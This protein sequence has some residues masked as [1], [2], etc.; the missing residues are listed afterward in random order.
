MTKRNKV[1]IT[2][3]LISL[4]AA[5]IGLIG[6]NVS[7]LKIILIVFPITLVFLVLGA[8]RIINDIQSNNI[9]NNKCCSNCR[10][11]K[12]HTNDKFRPIAICTL[13]MIEINNINQRY[14]INYKLI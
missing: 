12:I 5:I 11:C 14:C 2:C 8:I 7:E 9:S 3:L 4:I 1:T 6:R 10:Y 13:T